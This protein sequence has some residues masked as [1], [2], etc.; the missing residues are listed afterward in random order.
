MIEQLGLLTGMILQVISKIMKLKILITGGCGFIGSHILDMYAKHGFSVVVVDN[1]R[2]GRIQNIQHLVDNENMEFIFGDILDENFVN[3]LP[4]DIDI[5]NHHAA[6]LEITRC[7]DYPQED[8]MSNLIGTTNIMEFAKKCPNLK[9]VI[10]ASSAAVYGQAQ[11]N[12]QKETDPINPH[13]IYGVSKYSTELLANIYSDYLNIPFVGLRYSIIYGIREW[14]GRVLTLFIKNSI[15]D[16]KVVVFGKGEEIRDYCNVKDVVKLHEILIKQSL[17]RKN[18]IYNVSS[19]IKTSINELAKLVSQ[20]SG[21][22]IIYEDVK[23]GEASKMLNKSRIRLPGNLKYLCQDFSKAK[24]YFEWIP[25]V[26]LEEGI[27]EEYNWYKNNIKT[28]KYLWQK[29]FY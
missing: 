11:S 5:I 10:Y 6:Q 29:M 8:I 17:K 16:K 3:Q 27:I 1:F 20:I 13:W 7:I 9:K 25:Q 22:E 15:E 19:G 23:E 2:S 14:Y 12:L 24:N 18:V 4:K 21:C 28:D 26:K